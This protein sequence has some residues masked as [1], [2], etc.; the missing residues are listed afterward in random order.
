MILDN[1]IGE[2]VR[3]VELNAVNAESSGN[4]EIFCECGTAETVNHCTDFHNC[5]FLS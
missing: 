3:D 1:V 4:F 5:E 2:V